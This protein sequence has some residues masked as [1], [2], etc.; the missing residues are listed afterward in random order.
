MSLHIEAQR[1]VEVLDTFEGGHNLVG[2]YEE[3]P[4]A[5]HVSW[6]RG[7]NSASGGRRALRIV[8]PLRM[9]VEILEHCDMRSFAGEGAA[10]LRQTKLSNPKQAVCFL[11]QRRQW[12][13]VED[14]QPDLIHCKSLELALNYHERMIRFAF[15][16]PPKNG[17]DGQQLDDGDWLRKCSRYI[18]KWIDL[19]VQEK[20]RQM[21]LPDDFWP[22]WP[23]RSEVKNVYDMPMVMW[24]SK[25]KKTVC[26]PN[27]DGQPLPADC[28]MWHYYRNNYC[29]MPPNG[30]GLQSGEW[31]C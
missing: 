30:F 11:K 6:V 3:P 13:T 4:S 10:E 29:M 31:S 27:N 20:K 25:K 18:Q 15:H 9:A 2:T 23:P 7:T 19:I 24:L 1:L 26:K 28:G 21:Q 12:L 22:P 5:T 14:V 8:M 16:I 17:N